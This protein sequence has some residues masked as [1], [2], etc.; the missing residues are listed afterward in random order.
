MFEQPSLLTINLANSQRE[1]SLFA[2]RQSLTRLRFSSS[3]V[4]RRV[5]IRTGGSIKIIFMCAPPV[6]APLLFSKQQLRHRDGP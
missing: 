3:C 5:V 6:P 2:L 1:T 4:V